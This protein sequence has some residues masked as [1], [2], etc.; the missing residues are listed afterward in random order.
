MYYLA[1]S[2]DIV[3]HQQF[4]SLSKKVSKRSCFLYYIKL[5]KPGPNVGHQ[6]L[7]HLTFSE[8]MKL[9]YTDSSAEC[10]NRIGQMIST[11]G[12]L[13]SSKIKMCKF[14]FLGG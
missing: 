5:K 14:D 8:H 9:S 10:K 11:G 2:L 7:S 6:R 12:Q 1:I 4:G 13:L 3:D